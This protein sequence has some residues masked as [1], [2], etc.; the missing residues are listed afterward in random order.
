MPKKRTLKFTA[1]ADGDFKY[2]PREFRYANG[3][4]IAYETTSGPFTLRFEEE[5]KFVALRSPFQANQPVI[6]SKP[7]PGGT[8]IAGNEKVTNNLTEKERKELFKTRG[9]IA[10]Y[11]Y[12]ISVTKG[13]KVIKDASQHGVYEC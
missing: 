4:T 5:D 3:D 10:T 11:R 9:H 2:D 7:G 12:H 1:K 13:G 6:K 8:H